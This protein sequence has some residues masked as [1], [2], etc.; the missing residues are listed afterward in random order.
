VAILLNWWKCFSPILEYM[1][2]DFS[3]DVQ[4]VVAYL[5]GLYTANDT[6]KIQTLRGMFN[7]GTLEVDNFA[8]ACNF[9][10]P[11]RALY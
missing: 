2:K 5:D 6:S 4:A 1:P 7:L 11:F 9:S 3:A 10:L 8:W